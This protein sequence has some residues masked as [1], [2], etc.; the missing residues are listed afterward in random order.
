MGTLKQ[1]DWEINDIQ[2]ASTKHPL[3]SSALQASK[4]T[5]VKALITFTHGDQDK[6]KVLEEFI[7]KEV[8]LVIERMTAKRET[9]NRQIEKFDELIFSAIINTDDGWQ[10]I[11]SSL[12]E[13]ISDLVVLEEHYDVSHQRDELLD[14][15]KKNRNVRA[16]EKI[17]Q[18]EQ[19]IDKEREQIRRFSKESLM[20]HEADMQKIRN[21]IDKL[22]NQLTGS[23]TMGFHERQEIQDQIDK[24]RKDYFKAQERYI[25]AERE[26]FNVQDE[27]IRQL[28]GR[29]QLN[30][31][32]NEIASIKFNIAG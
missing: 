15:V 17:E 22:E 9:I 16:Q 26:Q 2:R 32:Y 5:Q 20:R 13:H 30:F 11:G 10:P 25:K 24:Q 8:Q 23:K 1:V 29:M 28:K 3:L 31:S 14:L 19:Y 12:I 21:E 6:R 7:G 4:D 27:L 18:N